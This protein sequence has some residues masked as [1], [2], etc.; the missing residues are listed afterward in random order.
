[1]VGGGD[2]QRLRETAEVLRRALQRGGFLH[3][4]HPLV[5]PARRGQ[6]EAPAP[7]R[8]REV[9]RGLHHLRVEARGLYVVGGVERLGR[10]LEG[11]DRL[12]RDEPEVVPNLLL[13]RRVTTRR[14]GPN[15]R[16]GR[17]QEEQE[18]E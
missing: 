16:G 1:M 5:A 8:R 18:Q 10:A 11:L 15:G 3:E 6:R 4:R 12:R 9:G 14:L 17:E 13:L 2:A 7:E